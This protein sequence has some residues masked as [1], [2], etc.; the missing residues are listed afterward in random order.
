MFATRRVVIACKDKTPRR[1]RTA[2]ADCPQNDF[3]FA[4]TQSSYHNPSTPR[5]RTFGDVQ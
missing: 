3:I 1:L 5:H 4:I 2:F